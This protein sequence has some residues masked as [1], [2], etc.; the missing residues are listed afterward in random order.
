MSQFE[1]ASGVKTE[2]GREC[3]LPGYTGSLCLPAGADGS[4][5]AVQ[6]E[7]GLACV[8][9]CV[10]E[11]TCASVPQNMEMLVLEE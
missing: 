1:Q 7:A 8:C 3:S 4:M 5:A 9:V 2:A 11:C 6:A 10:C